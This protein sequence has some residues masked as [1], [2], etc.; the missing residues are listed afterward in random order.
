MEWDDPSTII[1]VTIMSLVITDIVTIVAAI[2][3]ICAHT[4][5]IIINIICTIMPQYYHNC[6]IVCCTQ[7]D[8][9]DGKYEWRSFIF[10][11]V[12]ATVLMLALFN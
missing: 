11:I 6:Y 9:S 10:P 3:H 7:K 4:I 2:V 8:Q 5:E 12:T 1:T